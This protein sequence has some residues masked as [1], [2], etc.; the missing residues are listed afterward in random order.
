MNPLSP[1]L[2]MPRMFLHWAEHEARVGWLPPL[3][4]GVFDMARAALWQV[5]GC[6]MPFDA[7]R[8]RLKALPGT[9]VG[10]ALDV[11]ADPMTGLLIV[12]GSGVAYDPVQVS[13][14]ADSVKKAEVNRANGHKGGRPPK[15]TAMAPATSGPHPPEF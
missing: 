2:R 1:N 8:M 6:K 15:T 14:F 10:R 4:R 3:E 9:E 12:D 7:L 13:E 11:L 5:E